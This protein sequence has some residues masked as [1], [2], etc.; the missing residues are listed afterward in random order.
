M[1][2]VLTIADIRGNAEADGESDLI[3]KKLSQLEPLDKWSIQQMFE[4]YSDI[5]ANSFTDVR[6]S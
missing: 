1:D 4:D 2:L 3:E 6:P 5:V